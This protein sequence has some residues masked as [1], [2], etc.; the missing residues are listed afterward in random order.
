MTQES[1]GLTGRPPRVPSLEAGNLLPSRQTRRFH[2]QTLAIAG[3][4]RNVTGKAILVGGGTRSGKSDFSLALARSLGRRRLFIATAQPGD[5]EM[6]TRIRR[7]RETRGDD[8][9]T[10]EEPLAVAE[11]FRRA[12]DCDV[13]VLD[14]LTLWLSNLLLTG[15]DENAVSRRV[16][17]LANEF[18]RRRIH[19]VIVTSEVGLGLVPET[20]LGRTFRDLLGMANQRLAAV[21]D[22]VYFGVLGVM[23]RLKPAPVVPVTGELGR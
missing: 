16:D 10:M 4:A 14:C 1:K 20:P 6:R 8:F 5:D 12:Q 11:A 13:V 17:E 7:H 2:E 9:R 19:T 21:A 3:T 15:Q 22:E 23:L 18:D